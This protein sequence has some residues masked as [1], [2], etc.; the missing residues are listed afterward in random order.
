MNVGVVALVETDRT[1]HPLRSGTSN[2]ITTFIDGNGQRLFA[3]YVFPRI[4]R[5]TDLSMVQMVGRRDVHNVDIGIGKQRFDAFVHIGKV[6]LLRLLTSPFGRRTN[7]SFH[8]HAES[9][10]RFG[11]GDSHETGADNARCHRAVRVRT[12]TVCS[13][14]WADLAVFQT[15]V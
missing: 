7:D 14:G 12:H 3:Q 4:N 10:K 11:M 13:S 1:D 5:S 15:V 8:V 9:T 6:G 2:K